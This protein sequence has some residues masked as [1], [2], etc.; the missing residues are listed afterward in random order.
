MD[1]DFAKNATLD[2]LDAVPQDVKP[3]Y[4]Q[5]DGKFVLDSE[6]PAINSAVGLIAKLNQSLKGARND[7]AI[8]KSKAVDLSALSEYGTTPDEIKEAVAKKLEE[9]LS[10]KDAKANI[11]KIKADL[12]AGHA[13]DLVTK[14]TKISALTNQLHGLMVDNVATSAIAELKGN[15]KLLMPFI[16]EQVRVVEEDGEFKVF[17]VDKA[18]ERRYSGTTGSPMTI[19]ELVAE[20]KTQS[21][22]AGAFLSDAASGGGMKPGAAAKPAQTGAQPKSAVDKIAAGLAKR[23]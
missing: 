1:F 2:N 23:N 10:N 11:E 17:V 21:D 5:A 20:L 4:K 9:A 13:K 18:N 7:A 14:D 16:K 15:V 22:F 12:A 8:A 3:F 19:K 6:N